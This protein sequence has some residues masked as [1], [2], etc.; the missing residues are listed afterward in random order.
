MVLHTG[1]IVGML[2]GTLIL[3]LGRKTF[4][5]ILYNP[6]THRNKFNLPSHSLT[7]LGINYCD[8]IYSVMKRSVKDADSEVVIDMIPM[9]GKFGFFLSLR[10]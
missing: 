2:P 9:T 1:R 8:L 3:T 10:H 5:M 7:Q 6:K 4:V